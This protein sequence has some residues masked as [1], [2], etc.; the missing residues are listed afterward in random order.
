MTE[1]KVGRLR[2]ALLE[3]LDEHRADAYGLPTAGRFLFYELEQRGLAVK[4]SPNDRRRNRRRSHGWPP[5]AQD[6]ID[7]LTD[8]REQGRVPWEWIF[9]EGRQLVEWNH[10][11]SVLDYML[12]RLPEARVNPWGDQPPPLILCESRQVAGVLRR[13]ASDY[14]CPIAGT[15]GQSAGFL[16]TVVAPM[17]EQADRRVLYLGDLDRSG[18]D[19]ERN[20]QRVLERVLERELDWERIGMTPEQAKSIEPIWKTDGRDGIGHWAWE[21]ESLGQGAVVALVR[22]ALDALLP[23]PLA[24][25]LERETRQRRPVGRRLRR[26]Q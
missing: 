15:G 14:C 21:V 3:L 1:T 9:D 10:A 2:N 26:T 6:V 11:S 18:Q 16:R 5:G 7:A 8:L 12:D 4:P 19:I 22:S 23:E 24:D 17:F 25:V 13:I 20:A